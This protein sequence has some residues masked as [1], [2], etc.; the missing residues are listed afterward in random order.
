M[1]ENDTFI[2]V[3]PPRPTAPQ[4]ICTEIG[5]TDILTP[6]VF[7]LDQG[8]AASAKPLPCGNPCKCLIA[9]LPWEMPCAAALLPGDWRSLG[10]PVLQGV[11]CRAGTC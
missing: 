8:K 10:L 1:Y 3:P 4:N 6:F 11:A 5:I 9:G 2:L 7:A